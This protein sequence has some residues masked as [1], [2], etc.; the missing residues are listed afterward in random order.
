M[1]LQPC[2]VGLEGLGCNLLG[3]ISRFY[4]GNFYS[5]NAMST[6][7]IVPLANDG[8]LEATF[9][10]SIRRVLKHSNMAIVGFVSCIW[11]VCWV[12]S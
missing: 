11:S 4:V 2:P 6:I 9:R 8:H 10:M 7:V 1:Y 5:L 12:S 3:A